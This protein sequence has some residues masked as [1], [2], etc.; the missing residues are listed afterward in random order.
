MSYDKAI[1]QLTN[2]V[3]RPTLYKLTMPQKFIGRG[4]N[5]YLEYFCTTVTIPSVR[6]NGIN[7]PGHSLMGIN[8]I[9]PTSPVWTNPLD[10]TVIEN[11]DFDTYADFKQWFDRTGTGIDQ[12]GLRNIKLRYYD[13]IVG[14]IE[15]EKQEFAGESLKTPMRVRF[16]NAYIKALGPIALSSSTP[17][18]YTTFNVQFNYEAYTTDF[19]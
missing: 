7:V 10:I 1:G 16:L 17:N 18:T 2:S 13:D 19:S 3:S 5:D 11:S 9:Q 8:R 12:E 6:Y 4:T 15:L 14:D